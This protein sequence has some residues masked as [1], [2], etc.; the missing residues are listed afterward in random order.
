MS[1]IIKHYGELK[2]GDV[3]TIHNG[4]KDTFMTG[5]ITSLEAVPD[6]A[7][8]VLSESFDVGDMGVQY[9]YMDDDDNVIT[10]HVDIGDAI[11]YKIANNI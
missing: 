9:F 5:L 10:K 1:R 4:H 11:I 6:M 3:I 7:L 8:I 2:K